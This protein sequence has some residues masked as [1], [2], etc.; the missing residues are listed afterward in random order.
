MAGDEALRRWWDGLD[1]TQRQQARRA[2]ETGEMSEQ[3]QQSLK[4][5]GL[6]QR[7]ELAGDAL[8]A[9]IEIFLK[10]RH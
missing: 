1:D 9:D 8:P 5:G 10:A 3:L 7:G 2:E 4:D 6:L